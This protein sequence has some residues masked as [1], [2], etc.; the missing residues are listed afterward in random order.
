MDSLSADQAFDDLFTRR[1]ATTDAGAAA[2]LC[3]ELGY[4]VST[5]AMRERIEVL[6]RLADHAIYVACLSTEVV[7]WIEVSEAHHLQAESRAEIGGLVVSSKVRGRGVGRQLVS[8][9]ENWAL[10]KGLKSVVVRSRIDREAA[11]RFYLRQGYAQ[12]K[13]SAVFGKPLP[14]Q[15]R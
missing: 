6:A 1:I 5:D 4:P 13:T 3:G 2:Q 8:R 11:H 15:T 10:K 9:A 12:T 7:G 14:T